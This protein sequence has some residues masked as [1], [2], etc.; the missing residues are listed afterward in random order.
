MTHRKVDYA[1][2][3]DAVR[4]GKSCGDVARQFTVCEATVR[5]ACH[6]EGFN[7]V[8]AQRSN[9]AKR[10]KA[11][12]EMVAE[13]ATIATAAERFNV[14]NDTATNACRVHGLR[15]DRQRL[16][17]LSALTF[18]ILADL[19]NTTESQVTIARSFC[20]SRQYVEQLEAGARRA[21]IKL[22][23]SDRRKGKT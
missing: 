6:R 11:I 16:K 5:I 15:F 20:V 21:G 10:D 13:G 18:A 8:H 3:T 23:R 4:A 12:A 2:L 9:R 14:R 1:K 17:P 22:A 19:L 7:F